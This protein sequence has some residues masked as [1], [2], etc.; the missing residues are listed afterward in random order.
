MDTAVF[1]MSMVLTIDA[2]DSSNSVEI[3]L[4]NATLGNAFG[5]GGS[6]KIDGEYKDIP[7]LTTVSATTVLVAVLTKL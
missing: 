4:R 3:D 5:G 2:S 7:L 6:S 1:G